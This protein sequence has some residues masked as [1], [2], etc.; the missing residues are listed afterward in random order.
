MRTLIDTQGFLALSSFLNYQ[1]SG[2]PVNWRGI[3]DLIVGKKLEPSFEEI[4]IDAFIFLDEIYSGQK[5]RLGPLAILHPLRATSLLS[6]TQSHPTVIG[7]LTCLFHD[8]DEDIDSE[9]FDDSARER[10][11]GGYQVFLKKLGK[12]LADS[13]NHQVSYLTRAKN[14]KYYIYLGKLLK[15]AEGM[16]GLAA[17]KLADRL[18]NTLDLR[19][20]IHDPTN[21]IDC[22]QIIFDALYASSYRGL[23]TRQPHPIARKI[24]GAMR[25]YQLYKNA[26][27]LSLLRA[28]KINLD[29]AGQILF[30]SLATS[31]I[32]EAQSILVHI[33]AYHLSDPVKQRDLLR[34]VLAYSESGGLDIINEGENHRL[35]GLF[36]KHFEYGSREEKKKG[37]AELYEDKKLMGMATVA[38]VAIFANFI[39]DPNFTIRG[40]TST[41]ITPQS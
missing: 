11:E 4:L 9:A 21:D 31:S 1:L 22:Y 36:K 7:L 34:N 38:F 2:E 24:D 18:D 29:N 14:Q 17:I 40:I 12:D 33:F 32:K 10:L 6:K 30:Y 39:N 19:I 15:Q 26:V 3:L 8:K 28:E 27:F 25:L 41:G 16:P 13:L 37:L 5:R 20:D 23:R 35:D